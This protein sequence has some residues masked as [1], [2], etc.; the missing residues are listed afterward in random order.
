MQHVRLAHSVA[1]EVQHHPDVLARFEPASVELLD[2]TV[3]IVVYCPL[4]QV[5]RREVADA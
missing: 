1:P 5:A 2:D 3:E 4:S